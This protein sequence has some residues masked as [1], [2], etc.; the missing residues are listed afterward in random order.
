[1]R[2]GIAAQEVREAFAATAYLH[3]FRVLLAPAAF[4]HVIRHDRRYLVATRDELRELLQ[5]GREIVRRD[6]VPAVDARPSMAPETRAFGSPAEGA[7]T[8]RDLRK[9]AVR[10]GSSEL[11]G[12][13]STRCAAACSWTRVR[14]SP[15]GWRRPLPR[16]APAPCSA[17]SCSPSP[18][19]RGAPC[20][21]R[22]MG[23]YHLAACGWRRMA[24]KPLLL[25]AAVASRAGR[26]PFLLRRALT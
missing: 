21:T 11:R 5:L 25:N 18:C 16:A 22:T 13:R 17:T 7:G 2:A 6:I 23:Q 26:P 19:T 15:R 8:R 10:Q 12:R 14:P 24:P 1:M 20:S 9:E 3:S 4:G